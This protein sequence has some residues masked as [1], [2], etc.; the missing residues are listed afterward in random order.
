MKSIN[1]SQSEFNKTKNSF[2]EKKSI[3]NNTNLTNF[4]DTLSIFSFNQ[5]NN[6]IPKNTNIDKRTSSLNIKVR[7]K[8]EYEF[9]SIKTMQKELTQ[10]IY[11]KE[12]G[13]IITAVKLSN[14]NL[15]GLNNTNINPEF[16]TINTANHN[17]DYRKDNISN[18]ILL[19]YYQLNS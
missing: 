17:K 1:C 19:F 10:K 16:A 4:R 2:D 14:D 18:S 11:T 7:E 6:N 15:R 13:D 9:P 12:S 5:N 8:H 3:L